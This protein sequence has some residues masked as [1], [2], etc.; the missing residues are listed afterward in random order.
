MIVNIDTQI[1]IAL[2]KLVE[3]ILVGHLIYA[4]LEHLSLG[5]KAIV[6]RPEYQWVNLQIA[7]PASLLGVIICRDHAPLSR[8]WDLSLV[9]KVASEN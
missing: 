7:D 2:L 3:L 1:L 6:T 5:L 8:A 9:A 4:R